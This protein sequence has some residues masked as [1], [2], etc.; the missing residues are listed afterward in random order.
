LLNL[1]DSPLSQEIIS[2]LEQFFSGL[3]LLG[4]PTKHL[5]SEGDQQFFVY[6]LEAYFERFERLVWDGCRGDPVSC[7]SSKVV[8]LFFCCSLPMYQL[9]RNWRPTINVPVLA[10]LLT[11]LQKGLWRRAHE[12]DHLGE[13]D[14]VTQTAVLD[15][16]EE[17]S[18]FKQVPDLPGLVNN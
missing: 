11:A 12:S 17:S 8:S 5:A 14:L 1:R 4:K 15:R 7:S 10:T 18:A 9:E 2:L 3:P 6:S 16:I 13:M